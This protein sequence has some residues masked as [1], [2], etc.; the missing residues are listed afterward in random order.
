[1]SVHNQ[2]VTVDLANVS[3]EWLLSTLVSGELER[4][5][6]LNL[7]DGPF[8]AVTHALAYQA[9]SA[10]PTNFDC[11]LGYTLGYTAATFVDADR[12]G[13]CVHASNLH[14]DPHDWVPGGVP[15]TSMISTSAPVVSGVPAAG[16]GEEGTK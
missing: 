9:R 14:E 1:M 16:D 12:T 8:D 6:Q 2:E 3:T 7:F 10:L 15:L 5:R 11:D 4:R 13:L